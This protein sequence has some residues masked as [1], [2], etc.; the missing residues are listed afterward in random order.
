MQHEL[1]PVTVTDFQSCLFCTASAK[2]TDRQKLPAL[3]QISYFTDETKKDVATVVFHLHSLCPDGGA[4]PVGLTNLLRDSSIVKVGVG[5]QGDSTR[6][7]QWKLDVTNVHDIAEDAVLVGA[8]VAHNRTLLDIT[9]SVLAMT[10]LHKEV[11]SRFT[12]KRW[13]LAPILT[14]KEAME[15]AVC[16]AK[17]SLLA[18]EALRPYVSPVAATDLKVGDVVSFVLCAACLLWMQGGI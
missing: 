5:V 18:Y 7:K 3:L 15:Y 14:N 6:L 8:A 1:C 10:L 9:E 12:D 2:L 4:M 13:D 11:D 16:D 17:A